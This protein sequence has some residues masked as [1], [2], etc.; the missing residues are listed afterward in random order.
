MQRMRTRSPLLILALLL[1]A[2]TPAASQSAAPSA[3]ASELATTA[4]AGASPSTEA[5]ATESES[6]T[7][8][9]E[10]AAPSSGTVVRILDV[11]CLTGQ[12]VTIHFEIKSE[13]GIEKY[14]LW[15][16]WGGGGQMDQEPA[17]PLPMEI[18]DTVEFTHAMVDPEP[19]V[20]QF[21]L[22]AEMVGVADPIL[23]YEIEPDNRCPGH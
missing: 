11:E 2:C 16:T 21:G 12:T 14:G 20:H 7:A 3:P 9:P 18:E 5:T 6:A 1:A 19:R 4:S 22:Y 15:S 8:I 17:A 10:S 13:T 23:T